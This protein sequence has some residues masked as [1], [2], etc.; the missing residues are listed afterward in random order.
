ML[1]SFPS[2]FSSPLFSRHH[3]FC[4]VVGAGVLALPQAVAWL[5]WVAG[6]ICIIAFFIIQ[7]IASHMLAM[8]YCVNG[9]EH[10]RYHHAV[11]RILG[12]WNAV[13]LSFFQ[14]LNMSLITIAYTITGALSMK[15]IAT[16]ACSINGIE[17]CWNQSWKLTLLFSA[18]QV[19]LSQIRNLES[20]W[21]VS[22]LGA[23]TS[24]FYCIVALVLG[25]VYSGAHAGSVGGIQTTQANKAF[26][27]LNALGSIAFSYNFSLILI[28]IQDTLKQPPSAAKQMHKAVN[29]AVTGA[30]VFYLTVAVAGYVSLGNSVPGMVLEGFPDAPIG[31]MIAANVAILL[32]M[33]SA[34]QVYAQPLFDTMESHV[35]LRP[36]CEPRVTAGPAPPGA[37]GAAEVTGADAVRQN[38]VRNSA[39]IPTLRPEGW[40]SPVRISARA[41]SGEPT[42]VQPRSSLSRFSQGLHR[43]S[44]T[45]G[46][47]HLDTG[48]TNETVP[49][50]DEHYL[51]PLW[52]R[53]I[54]RTAYV[55]F[56]AIL[57]C[58][59]PFFGSIVGLVGALTYLPLSVLYPFWMYYVVYKPGRRAKNAMLTVFFV[60]LLVSAAATVGAFRNIIIGWKNFKIFGD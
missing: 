1:T 29:V 15:A 60:M 21:W 37:V 24:L 13:A 54:I 44:Q 42:G 32:H 47:Y 25:L 49:L 55:C 52:Q 10:A 59:L 38:I 9:V 39:P 50:N 51:V 5:G 57:G 8:V 12:K 20:A 46:M 40:S 53:L 41:G 56:T 4:A 2:P 19:V 36:S 31:L 6:P 23:I 16:F 58:V 27:I 30:F 11:K 22:T 14:I 34:Y 45:A 18:S 17:N 28:E 43:L 48:L 7:I 33:V 26:G 3:I 35:K